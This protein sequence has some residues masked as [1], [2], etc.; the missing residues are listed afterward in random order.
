MGTATFATRVRC[1]RRIAPIVAERMG[2]AI[3]PRNGAIDN[4]LNCGENTLSVFPVLDRPGRYWSS[5][6]TPSKQRSSNSC[7]RHSA[8]KGKKSAK[9]FIERVKADRELQSRFDDLNE[10]TIDGLLAVAEQT[11]FSFGA[12]DYEVAAKE[13]VEEEHMVP[14]GLDIYMCCCIYSSNTSSSNNNSQ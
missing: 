9:A 6:T 4:L 14:P 3:R 13:A 12:D 1:S 7:P 10:V 5:K 11:G 2:N 8:P